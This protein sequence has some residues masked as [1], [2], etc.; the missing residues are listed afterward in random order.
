MSRVDAYVSA[1]S[2][3]SASRYLFSGDVDG[4]VTQPWSGTL[5]SQSR[6][7]LAAPA[8]TGHIRRRNPWSAEPKLTWSHRCL[9][10]QAPAIGQNAHDGSPR[11]TPTIDV[12][13]QASL[14]WCAVQPP[15]PYMR[16]AVSRPGT[17]SA[18]M[19]ACSGCAVSGRLA[20]SAG[21]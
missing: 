4:T 8:S 13:S 7:N 9:T 14:F 5:M 12:Y 10:N 17:L 18:R 15:A 19:K 2:A 3:P 21:Q 11:R 20:T 6:P 16:R 1:V